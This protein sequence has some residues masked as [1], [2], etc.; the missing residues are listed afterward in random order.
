MTRH[1]TLL[2]GTLLLAGLVPAYSHDLYLMPEKF[3]TSPGTQLRIMFENGDE[4]PLGMSSVKPERLQNTR[5]ISSGGKANF[6]N[7]VAEPKRTT[8][9]VR[10][11]AAGSAILTAQTMPSLI[12][13][14]PKKFAAYLEHEN[15]T[16]ALKWRKAHKETEK[17]GRERYR[18]CVKSLIQA[19][20]S[21]AFYRERTGL[22][23]EIIPEAD[24]Y[25]LQPGAVLPVQVLFRGAPAADVAVESA[26]LENGKS[27]MQI[28]GR[29][30]A[31]GRVRVPVKA[32][33]PYRL[34]AIVMERCAEPKV[35]DWESFWA[36][37]TF[38]IQPKR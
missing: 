12:E 22:A 1:S 27:K 13:L 31:Q 20:K 11:P 26:W 25:S 16:N 38:E 5:L 10:V 3:V 34:H 35:A 24:P 2:L 18:K 14:T 17:A 33:G 4:F 32:I 36:S 7:I 19:G 30:D 15:L 28:V 8:A 23:I 21:D 37:L 9:T 6:E 29:T